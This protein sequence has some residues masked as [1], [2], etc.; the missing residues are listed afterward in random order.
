MQRIATHYGQPK[1]QFHKV[2]T[3]PKECTWD[4]ILKQN[5]IQDIFHFGQTT[6]FPSQKLSAND[7]FNVLI[8]TEM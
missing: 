1:L 3:P 8:V 4:A 7:S 2:K 6:L 5:H